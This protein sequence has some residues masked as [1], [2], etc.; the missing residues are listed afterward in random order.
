MGS[1][2]LNGDQKRGLY[3]EMCRMRAFEEALLQ[4]S[5]DGVLR[6]SL[7][8]ATGQEA[9]PAAAG[10]ALK[11]EDSIT[12]TYRGHGY[13]ISKGC[14]LKLVIAEILGREGGLGK[15]YGGKM[16]LFDLENGLLGSNGIVGG[17]V[18]T[19]C[20]AA[21][22]A[23]LLGEH[24]VALTV[25]GD[26][27][28][29]QGVV[30][31]SLN[32]AGMWKLPV[33]FL[34][35]NNLYAEMTPLGRSSA[36]T[37]IW[38]RLKPYHIEA[39]RIDGN[40]VLAAYEALSMARELAIRGNGPTF[41]EAMTYRTCGHYQLDPGLSYR[42]KEE[43]EAWKGRS[44]ID[45]FGTQLREENIADDTLLEDLAQAAKVEVQEAIDWALTSPVASSQLLKEVAAWQ[46]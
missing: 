20:G 17:A 28:F 18:P 38:K 39:V 25:F 43:V 16:H 30:H 26:G 10:L 31:E 6:G 27:A 23:Q 5:Q 42:T 34:C 29:N 14:D 8:L 12:V 13:V 4:L 40:D 24:R 21:L 46:R 7:H 37:E 22:S 35:E 45:R 41:I 33:I 32:M 15:G 19:A 2:G 1:A 3:R 9:L 44:P 11:R 36:E